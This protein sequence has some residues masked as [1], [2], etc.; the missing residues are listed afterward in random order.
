[1]LHFFTDLFSKHNQVNPKIQIN[2]GLILLFFLLITSCIEIV[3]SYDLKEEPYLVINCLFTPDSLFT[4]YV[5]SNSSMLDTNLKVVDNATVEI[6]T[7]NN[8]IATLQYT[9][10][11][12][13]KTENLKPTVNI[14]YIL[15]VKAEGYPNAEATDKIP[16]NSIEVINANCYVDI[17]ETEIVIPPGDIRDSRVELSFK[18]EDNSKINYYVITN[19]ALRYDYTDSTK[20]T[21]EIFEKTTNN[22]ILLQYFDGT[23]FHSLCFTNELAESN[24]IS[25]NIR[26]YWTGYNYFPNYYDEY[27]ADLKIISQNYFNYKADLVNYRYHESMQDAGSIDGNL[28][29]NTEI[30]EVFSNIENGYGIFAGYTSE[31]IKLEKL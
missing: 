10:N 1:M 9:Q 13:Y 4:V 3:D 5:H 31:Q 2:Q 14:Q 12:I 30:N 7:D 18:E 27:F 8:L 15:K 29:F 25:F 17:Y 16:D 22:P 24:I 19:Y 20:I 6:W 28:F 26:L 23:Q 11:G 21:Y